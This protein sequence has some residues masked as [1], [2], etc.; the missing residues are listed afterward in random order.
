MKL[1][2]KY[3]V[4]RSA[5][6]QKTTRVA[7]QN[8]L[9]WFSCEAYDTRL[10]IFKSSNSSLEKSIIYCYLL[11]TAAFLLNP[12]G[13]PCLLG[14]TNFVKSKPAR[15]PDKAVPATICNREST[16][17]SRRD[18]YTFVVNSEGCT[19]LHDLSLFQIR[20]A[21]SIFVPWA[22]GRQT[23]KGFD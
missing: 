10:Y 14:R 12:I 5:I 13:A 11:L 19:F 22:D 20:G 1:P 16:F 8:A 7:Q 4:R 6:K 17:N 2:T 9:N 3:E 15:P 18:S 23:S 21:C